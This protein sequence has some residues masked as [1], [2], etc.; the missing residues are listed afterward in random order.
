[1][2]GHVLNDDYNNIAIKPKHFS[3]EFTRKYKN[4]LSDIVF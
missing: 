2:F 4:N 3:K 1:M